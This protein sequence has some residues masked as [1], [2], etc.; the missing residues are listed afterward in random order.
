MWPWPKSWARPNL[1]FFKLFW[2]GIKT[3]HLNLFQSTI[4]VA[5][6]K[7]VPFRR[8]IFHSWQ[9]RQNTQITVTSAIAFGLNASVIIIQGQQ[10]HG[11]IF[12]SETLWCLLQN[13][14]IFVA[15][16]CLLQ[17]RLRTASTTRSWA[18]D[19]KSQLSKSSPPPISLITTSASSKSK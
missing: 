3:F 15:K 19:P 8:E 13:I 1:E 14:L 4:L 2:H 7:P 6:G 17:G 9:F 16:K 12:S 10:Q 18:A 5:L 11:N